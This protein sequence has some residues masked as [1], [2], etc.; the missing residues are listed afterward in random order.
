M[1]LANI[2]LYIVPS[3][4][5]CLALL[6]SYREIVSMLGFHFAKLNKLSFLTAGSFRSQDS[7]LAKL[8]LAGSGYLS[9]HHC[10]LGMDA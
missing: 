10:L 7:R 2:A 9:W 6:H 8:P 1:F 3:P 5:K 4:L